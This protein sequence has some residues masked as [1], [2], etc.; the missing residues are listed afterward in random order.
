MLLEVGFLSNLFVPWLLFYGLGARGDE[1]D[2]V[3]DDDDGK[4]NTTVDVTPK[5]HSFFDVSYLS[6]VDIVFRCFFVKFIFNTGYV[7]MNAGCRTW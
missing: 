6:L 3:E 5:S 4:N 1:L 2:A 7:K